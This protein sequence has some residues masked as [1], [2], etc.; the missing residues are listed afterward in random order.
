MKSQSRFSL[1]PELLT[2]LLLSPSV[3]IVGFC[4][5]LFQILYENAFTVMQAKKAALFTLACLAP[6][7][8]E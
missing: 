8:E 4:H 5:G 2:L 7:R 1:A 6:W 3:E